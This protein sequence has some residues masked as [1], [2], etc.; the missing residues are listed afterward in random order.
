MIRQTGVLA[1]ILLAAG[2]RDFDRYSRVADDKGLVPADVFARYGSEQAQE[3]LEVFR[4]LIVQ[5]RLPAEYCKL[6]SPRL[7]AQSI[8]PITRRSAGVW[9]SV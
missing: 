9:L 5:T 1:L 2:C 7:V 4:S 3:L 6:P 8:L